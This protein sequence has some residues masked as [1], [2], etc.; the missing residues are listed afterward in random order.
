MDSQKTKSGPSI[1]F[2]LTL[3]QP[4]DAHYNEFSYAKLVTD[5]VKKVGIMFVKFTRAGW[6]L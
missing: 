2:N 1:R 3:S 4:T 5:A 6:F